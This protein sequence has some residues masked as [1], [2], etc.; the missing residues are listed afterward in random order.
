MTVPISPSSAAH[1]LAQAARAFLERDPTLCAVYGLRPE[2]AGDDAHLLSAVLGAAIADPARRAHVNALCLDVF[3]SDHDALSAT[4]SDIE[5]TGRKDSDPNG[6]DGAHLFGNG[7]QAIV[8]HRAAHALWRQGRRDLGR[9]PNRHIAKI[10]RFH[11]VLGPLDGG[12]HARSVLP[13][14]RGM[15][16]VG[17][18]PA[19]EPTWQAAGR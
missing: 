9:G 14:G 5:T 18:A 4:L 6:A 11:P 13:V 10:G 2:D 7:L 19:E 3:A 1:S 16:D 8:G 15:G 12:D 17:A